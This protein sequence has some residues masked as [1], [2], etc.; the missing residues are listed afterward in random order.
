MGMKVLTKHV[1]AEFPA[2]RHAL[3]EGEL[4]GNFSV[5]GKVGCIGG[6][7]RGQAELVGDCPWIEYFMIVR[8]PLI[9]CIFISNLRLFTLNVK[10][11]KAKNE[12]Y[13]FFYMNST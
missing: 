13:N 2:N 9:I 3:R 6:F 5:F 4:A 11:G 10:V 7:Y 8:R 1:H 12:H